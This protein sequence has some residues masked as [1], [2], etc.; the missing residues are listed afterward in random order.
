[1][2]SVQNP[3]S[4]AP[5]GGPEKT[6]YLHYLDLFLN[7]NKGI[8]MLINIIGLAYVVGAI[9]FGSYFL[10]ALARDT[11]YEERNSRDHTYKDLQ[12]EIIVASIV[13]PLIVALLI[14]TLPFRIAIKLGEN[15]RK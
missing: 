7:A 12:S 3:A 8:M 5:L 6:M 4:V 11:P 14:G 9:A 13:W 2:N 10:Y 15:N 1:V